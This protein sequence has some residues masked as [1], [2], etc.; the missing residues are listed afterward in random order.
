MSNIRKGASHR[1]EYCVDEDA[2]ENKQVGICDNLNTV[3]VF[4]HLQQ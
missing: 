4:Q 3:L 2:E 1:D